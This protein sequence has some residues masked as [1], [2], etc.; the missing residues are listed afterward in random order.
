MVF[1]GAPRAS[2]RALLASGPCRDRRRRAA[3]ARTGAG[4]PHRSPAPQRGECIEHPSST[5]R[6]PTSQA[7]AGSPAHGQGM[8]ASAS[9]SAARS[10][11]DCS[12]ATAASTSTSRARAAEPS[13]AWTRPCKWAPFTRS[14]TDLLVDAASW[15]RSSAEMPWPAR[16]SWPSV[17]RAAN[18][19][20]RAATAFTSM[21]PKN[22]LPPTSRFARA[23]PRTR[24]TP[25]ASCGRHARSL[26]LAPS[27]QQPVRF[28]AP[29]S[30]STRPPS[31]RR[32]ARTAHRPACRT[33][34]R[35]LV[36]CRL[37]HLSTLTPMHRVVRSAL[38]SAHHGSS[39]R[40]PSTP[41]V[42]P[43][44]RSTAR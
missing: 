5:A 44:R 27:G 3:R 40:P 28:S 41:R 10:G 39:R 35:H 30:A 17:S 9:S 25:A 2:A 14:S 42:P 33:P 11:W 12:L 4:L 22:Q 32:A 15:A 21:R 24:R 34:P 23:T 8:T 36:T 31:I 6:L 1:A 37:S 38:A 7:H 29:A 19:N 18:S 20:A 43:G 13:R 26:F 16:T